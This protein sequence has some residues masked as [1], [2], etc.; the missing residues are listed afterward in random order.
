MTTA[1]ELKS[2]EGQTAVDVN[3]A[4][5][6]KIGQIYVDDQTG[7]PLWVTIA[8]GMFGTKQNFAPLYG[9][10]FN[11]GDLQLAV[12]RDMVRDAP[13]I[14]ADGH[15]RDSESEAPVRLLQRVPRRQGTGPVPAHLLRGGHP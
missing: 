1:E 8:T 15:I 4:K 2:M 6:G 14:E 7:Q 12:T 5:L 9:S 11:G 3:G 13:G 10:R